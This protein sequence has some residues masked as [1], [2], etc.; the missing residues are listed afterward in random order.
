MNGEQRA[1]GASA[2]TLPE[3]E[4]RLHRSLIEAMLATSDV[5]T[6]VALAAELGAS[7][8]MLRSHLRTLAFADYLGFDAAGHLTCL[9]PFSV[10]PTQHVVVIDGATE[11]RFVMCSLDALGIAAMLGRAVEIESACPVCGT[12]IRLVVRPSAV[13]S[14]A[15]PETVVVAKRDADAPAHEACCGFTVFACG[16]EHADA[17]LARTSDTSALDLAAALHVGEAIFAGMLGDMLPA[18][19]QR[20]PI[21]S[22]GT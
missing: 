16:A 3:T 4:R 5:P 22:E 2:A 13:V 11:R 18:K 1:N 20:A 19:R 14:I 17:L 6:A 12:P 9:Y 15:P 7:L 10:I 8:D 21:P